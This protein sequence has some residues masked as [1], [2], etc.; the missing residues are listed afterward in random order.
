MHLGKIKISSI[1]M[2]RHAPTARQR[3]QINSYGNSNFINLK[4]E[5]NKVARMQS[6]EYNQTIKTSQP[7]TR[8]RETT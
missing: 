2:G 6:T 7:K 5:N 4:R 8:K 3:Q 1:Y